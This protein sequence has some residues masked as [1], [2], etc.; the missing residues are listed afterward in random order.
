MNFAGL[1]MFKLSESILFEKR[2]QWREWLETNHSVKKEIWL[3]HHKKHSKGLSVT[4]NDA[5]E[6]ALCFGW[7][8]STLKRIDEEKFALRYSPRRKG[9]I[10]AESNKKR[11]ELMIKQNLMTDA[12][13]IKIIEAKKNGDWHKAA[14]IEKAEIPADLEKALNSEKNAWQNFI[15]FSKSHKKQYLYWI[16]M[17][18]KSETRQKRI[19]EVVRRSCENKKPGMK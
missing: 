10:W 6:E 8:D 17:A 16:M 18:K 4:Y 14:L 7:I 9:S 3:V 12:G 2:E 5:V 13:L 15:K 11:V 1:N 19:N